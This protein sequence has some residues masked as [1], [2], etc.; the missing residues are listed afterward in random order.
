MRTARKT[1]PVVAPAIG[2]AILALTVSAVP[3][4]TASQWRHYS[5]TQ[6]FVSY[7]DTGTIRRQG[8]L[9]TYRTLRFYRTPQQGRMARHAWITWSEARCTTFEEKDYRMDGLE[10]DGSIGE[11]NRQG[12]VLIAA[13]PGT[14]GYSTISH[15]C[16][17]PLTS[18]A[19]ATPAAVV[20]DAKVR[21]GI[22]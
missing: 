4:Q 18:P 19:L 17:K 8:D 11:T 12:G 3:A 5:T 1:R 15:A 22:R 6:G 10:A 20:A 14:V 9:V 2:L 7:L 21:L 16:G 13:T